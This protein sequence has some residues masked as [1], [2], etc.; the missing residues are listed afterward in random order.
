MGHRSA[1]FVI[2]IFQIV[3]ASGAFIN[4]TVP[5]NGTV[6]TNITHVTHVVHHVY[7]P[8]L[9]IGSSSGASNN[10][11]VTLPVPHHGGSTAAVLPPLATITTASPVASGIPLY[12][13]PHYDS[14]GQALWF[15]K[16]IGGTPATRGEFP[17]KVSLQLATNGAHFCGGTLLTLKHVLTA[18]HCVTDVHGVPWSVSRIQ[19]MADD[20]NVLPKMGSPTRQVRQVKSLN[21]HEQ[22]NAKRLEHD[23]ALLKLVSEFTQTDTL[24]PAKR[25]S[26]SPAAGSLCALAGWGVTSE[27]SQ[28]VSPTLQRV[29][30]EV[31][32]FEQCNSAYEGTLIRGMMCAAAPGRDACQGDSGGALMCKNKVV[33]V[34]S[35]GAGCAHPNF[36]S[37]HV[38]VV[39]YEKWISKALNGADRFGHSFAILA[40]LLSVVASFVVYS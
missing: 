28:T 7:E 32:A 23:I 13:H 38:D 18:A 11:N 14:A 19:A 8:I 36:P 9:P 27:H 10:T 12:K 20:L 26:S 34:V 37:V 17:S 3:L 24:Y 1:I 30:M 6:I 15:P 40:A 39:H 5:Q 31:V 22:Y 21:I 29:N 33:G 4:G 2:G 35:F 25:A 16:I